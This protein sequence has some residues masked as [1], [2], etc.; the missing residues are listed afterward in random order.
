MYKLYDMRMATNW[1]SPTVY[2]S[3]SLEEVE[4]F[5]E[6]YIRSEAEELIKNGEFFSSEL[7]ETFI[8]E[9]VLILG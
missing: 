2:E 9:H 6:E 5:A 4:E 1:S 8:R 3:S 7:A